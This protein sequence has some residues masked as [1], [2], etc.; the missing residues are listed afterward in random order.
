MCVCV[1]PCACVNQ[2]ARRAPVTGSVIVQASPPLGV[3][4]HAAVVIQSK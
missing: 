2:G 4:T 3:P 1:R